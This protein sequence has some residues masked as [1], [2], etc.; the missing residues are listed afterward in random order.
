MLKPTE[1]ATWLGVSTSTVR[2]WS[3]TYGE[4][5]SAGAT[6]GEGRHRAYSELDARVLAHVGT[7]SK[8]GLTEEEVLLSLDRLQGEDWVDL[9]VMPGKPSDGLPMRLVSEDAA[10]TALVTIRQNLMREI[11]LKESRIEDLTE[12][13]S[14]AK[15][16][17]TEERQAREQER[18]DW[19]QRAD[20]LQTELRTSREEL[21]E[22]RG[23]LSLLETQEQQSRLWLKWLIIAVSVLAV[24]AVLAVL[25]SLLV[26]TGG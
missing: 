10:E 5:L 25:I 7:L 14:R 9:P 4:Y 21:G 11:A 23:K 8:Q 19:Q 24:V 22:M 15:E 2:R 20:N 16:E 18:A 12:D 17:L 13:L 26:Q 6:G 1:L 3:S